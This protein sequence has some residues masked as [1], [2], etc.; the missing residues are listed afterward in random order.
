MEVQQQNWLLEQQCQEQK[1]GLQQSLQHQKASLEQQSL[2]LSMDY[3]C[4]KAEEHMQ[5]Q[6]YEIHPESEYSPITVY[7]IEFCVQI[8]T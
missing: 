8:W 2:Q 3:Q 4:K 7:R 5:K 1:M 6:V